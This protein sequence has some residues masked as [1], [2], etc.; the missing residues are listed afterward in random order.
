MSFTRATDRLFLA[1]LPDA[2]QAQDIAE[3]AWHLRDVHRLEGRPL[4]PQH[5]HATL[6][7]V[8]DGLF[9]PPADLIEELVQRLSAIDMPCFRVSF[10]HAVSFGGGAFVLCGRDGVA[11]LEALREQVRAAL[12]VAHEDRAPSLTPP[13]FTPPPFTPHVTLLRDR[14]RV[15]VHE[16]VAPIEWEVTEI[17]LVHS[18]LGKTMHHHIGRVPLKRRDGH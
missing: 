11:G 15:P 2:G 9:A 10:D 4:L 14:R 18:L 1:A 12:A 7:H 6:W 8:Y 13:A 17:V 3:L 16:L 5:L